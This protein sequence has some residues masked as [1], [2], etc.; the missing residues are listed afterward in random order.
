MKAADLKTKSVAELKTLL[1]ELRRKQFKLRLVK[2]GG[3]MNQTH[4]IRQT[5]RDVARIETILTEKEK[6]SS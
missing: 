1:S 2:A 4:F 3:E 5:R 6:V